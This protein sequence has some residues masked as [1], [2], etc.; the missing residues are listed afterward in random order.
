MAKQEDHPNLNRGGNEG[1]AFGGGPK[2]KNRIVTDELETLMGEIGGNG[3]SRRQ[4]ARR[5]ADA[6]LEHAIAGNGAYLKALMDRLEGPITQK[7]EVEDVSLLTDEERASRAFSLLES[8]RARR[9]G[10]SPSDE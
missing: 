4:N 2:P 1:N 10:S 3:K 6:I 8:A 9:D 7:L 5:L